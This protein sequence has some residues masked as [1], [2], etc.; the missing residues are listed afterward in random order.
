MT[1]SSPCQRRREARRIFLVRMM[2]RMPTIVL[3]IGQV[4]KIVS[5]QPRAPEYGVANQPT[6]ARMTRKEIASGQ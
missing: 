2:P 4:H 3:T 5:G 1:G 6:M